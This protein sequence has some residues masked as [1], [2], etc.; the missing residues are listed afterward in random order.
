M[1]RLF[2]GAFCL[3]SAILLSDSDS[4]CQ[5]LATTARQM[6]AGAWKAV[7]FYQG[8]SNQS[9][10]F[11]VADAGTCTGQGAFAPTFPCGQTGNVSASG[12]GAA[13]I[14]KLIFQP[15]ERLQYYVSAGA[16]N[17]TLTIPTSAGDERLSG[18]RQGFLYGGGFRAVLMP[19]IAVKIGRH[20]MDLDP[21]A[22]KSG[23]EP[24]R[25]MRPALTLDAG[26][27]LQRYYFN[28]MQPVTAAGDQNIDQRLDLWQL[29]VALEASQR[30]EFS[31]SDL[32]LEPYGGVRWLSNRADLKDLPT[33]QHRGGIKQS[34]SPIVGLNIPV[35]KMEGIF[36]EA[37]F[38]D[39]IQYGAGLNIRFK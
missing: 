29:Q 1:R 8:I 19:E 37:S 30:F 2:A 16:G 25:L 23:A 22:S 10:N 15:Y 28:Q 6:D 5:T 4:A 3:L 20:H 18:D 21:Q 17:Y 36:A 32:V 38:V 12:D 13:G 35:G 27:G 11:S 24:L 9:L 34:V 33:G 31:D 14:F 39:G 26:G 7:F